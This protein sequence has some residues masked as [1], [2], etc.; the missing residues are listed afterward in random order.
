MQARTGCYRLS[1]GDQWPRPVSAASATESAPVP[2]LSAASRPRTASAASKPVRCRARS[3]RWI[4]AAASAGG[5]V[6]VGTSGGGQDRRVEHREVEGVVHPVEVPDT[7]HLGPRRDPLGQAGRLGPQRLRRA[8][9][10]AQ[11]E[12]GREVDPHPV[13]RAAALDA[14]VG[15]VRERDV[16]QRRVAVLPEYRAHP[17]PC[18]RPECPRLSPIGYRTIRSC[19]RWLSRSTP[20]GVTTTMSSIRTP[21]RPGR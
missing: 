18:R 17:P 11:A 2:V 4:S 9:Q 15:G 19:G 1:T 3:A 6:W 13:Q 21:C 20:S 12:L 14:P 5:R 8:V 7:V 16:R 10:V